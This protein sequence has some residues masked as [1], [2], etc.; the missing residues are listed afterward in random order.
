MRQMCTFVLLRNWSL[1]E[2]EGCIRR[3]CVDRTQQAAFQLREHMNYTRWR[4]HR[5][6]TLRNDDW[7]TC[8]DDLRG[9]GSAGA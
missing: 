6:G 9:A 3:C 1:A 5:K 7:N 8:E 4:L 2:R